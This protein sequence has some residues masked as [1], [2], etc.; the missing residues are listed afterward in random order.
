M[1]PKL[2]KVNK[3]DNHK[4]LVNIIKINFN[5]LKNFPSSIEEKLLKSSFFIYKLRKLVRKED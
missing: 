5:I 3:K 2:G 1:K 4:N